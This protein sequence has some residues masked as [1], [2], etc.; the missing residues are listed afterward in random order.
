MNPLRDEVQE[1]QERW[2]SMVLDITE[3]FKITCDEARA[4]PDGDTDARCADRRALSSVA[5][6]DTNVTTHATGVGRRTPY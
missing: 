2:N 1:F 3:D 4:G 5:V 6:R